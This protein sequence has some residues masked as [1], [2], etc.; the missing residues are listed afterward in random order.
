[1]SPTPRNSK[2]L[3]TSTT[4][5]TS[6]QTETIPEPEVSVAAVDKDEVGRAL[7]AVYS[8]LKGTWNG[9]MYGI[10]GFHGTPEVEVT[11][12]GVIGRF[13]LDLG[14]HVYSLSIVETPGK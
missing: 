11:R 7:N 1:M 10:S 6:N 9:S 3:K 12:D 13:S 5:T 2:S 4:S 14:G 8:L